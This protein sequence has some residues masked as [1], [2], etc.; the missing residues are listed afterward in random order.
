MKILNIISLALFCFGCLP[1]AADDLWR[2]DKLTL[3]NKVSAK[4]KVTKN[5]A[6]L[7]AVGSSASR[8]DTIATELTR[9]WVVFNGQ[10]PHAVMLQDTALTLGESCIE[11]DRGRALIVGK[12]CISIA[13]KQSDAVSFVSTQSSVVIERLASGQYTV[14]TLAGQALIGPKVNL[15]GSPSRDLNQYP[16]VS[17]H[18]G[19]ATNGY[20]YLYPSAGGLIT[21]SLSGYVP[22]AQRR[23]KSIAYSYSVAGTNFDGFWGASTEI[24]YRWFSPVNQSTSSVYVAYSGFD[25]PTCYSNFVNLGGQW[26]RARWRLGVTSGLNTG[27]CDA[28]FSFGALNLSVPIAKLAGT[29]SAYFNVTPY[30]LFGDNLFSPFNYNGGG[31]SISPGARLSLTIPVTDRVGI[32]AY[33]GVDGVY[34]AMIGGRLSMRFPSG[35]AIVKDTNI[36]RKVSQQPSTVPAAQAGPASLYVVVDEGYKATFANQGSLQGAVTKMSPKEIAALIKQYME[37]IEPLPESNRIA[38]VAAANRALTTSVAGILGVSFLESASLPVSQTAQQPFDVTTV[39][40]TASFACASS[41]EA[42]DYAE[43]RLRQ[44]SKD[45]TADLVAAADVI[46]LGKGENAGDAWPV[47]TSKSRA[48]R[49]ANGSVCN[50]INSFINNSSDY[51]GPVNPLSTIEL[52]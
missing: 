3:V 22:L 36:P 4:G 40:P 25:S 33:G 28:A 11:L 7:L 39:F 52:K 2:P 42:K 44:D 47:T 5:T 43:L 45:A 29:R 13:D 6:E 9:A 30:L 17:S 41:G 1:A 24:G 23:Q 35:G 27:G 14:K 26:E 15:Q 38:N 32:D 18:L 21:G 31:S 37:G 51:Q 19:L 16:S 50:T 48:Y 46:Y 10:N 12:T 34:G 49:M 8:S 20:T